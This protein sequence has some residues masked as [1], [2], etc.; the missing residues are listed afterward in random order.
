MMSKKDLEAASVFIHYDDGI[1]EEFSLLA[2][3]DVFDYW[4]N[5]SSRLE[6]IQNLDDEKIGWIG[7]CANKWSRSNQTNL[8]KTLNP[9]NQ[10]HTLI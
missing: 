6:A 4:V 1:K 3:V 9:I 10:Y 8:D 2:K 5:N 7:T